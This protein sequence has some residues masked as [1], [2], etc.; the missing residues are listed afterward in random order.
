MQDHAAVF[1]DLRNDV[2][3]VRDITTRRFD[4]LRQDLLR[5]DDKVDRHFLWLVGMLVTGLLAVLG[6]VLG[7]YFK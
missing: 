5:L 6:T 3:E 7:L 2:R 4:D 1:D